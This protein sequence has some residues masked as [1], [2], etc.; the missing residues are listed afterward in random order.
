[1]KRLFLSLT[2]A[3]FAVSA[4]AQIN[5]EKGTFAEASAK[6]KAES[7]PLYIEFYTTW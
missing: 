7:K 2:M 6:A 5:F 1:M 3:I 4:F